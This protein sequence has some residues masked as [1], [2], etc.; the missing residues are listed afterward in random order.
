MQRSKP[1][2]S[3][4][5]LPNLWVCL[6]AWSCFCSVGPGWTT[7]IQ[8]WT[9]RHIQQT[10]WPTSMLSK[11]TLSPSNTVRQR[12]VEIWLYGAPSKNIPTHTGKVKHN[13][14]SIRKC[15]LPSQRRELRGKMR[16]MTMIWKLHRD[17]RHEKTPQ[18]SAQ[19]TENICGE[20]TFFCFCQTPSSSHWELHNLLTLCNFGALLFSVIFLRG[21]TV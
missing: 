3:C 1:G 10:Y 12:P 14:L 21:L 4:V 8:V 20:L 5:F 9:V 15:F 11:Q 16:K 17:K 13:S 2:W 7:W 18:K 6:C 19:N